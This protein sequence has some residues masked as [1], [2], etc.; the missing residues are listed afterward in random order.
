ML[1]HSIR[2]QIGDED[3]VGEGHFYCEFCCRHFLDK[4]VLAEHE[5]SKDHKR[6]VKKRKWDEEA[7]RKEAEQVAEYKRKRRAAPGV[8][9]TQ[10]E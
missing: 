5:R 4:V 9:E 10:M 8:T 1:D 3:V 6:K 2:L 7:D